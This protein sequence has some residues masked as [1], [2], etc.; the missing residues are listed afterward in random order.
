M[1]KKTIIQIILLAILTIFVSTLIVNG[2]GINS[3]Y[4]LGN[5]IK[6]IFEID[7][8]IGIL[9]IVLFSLKQINQSYL[10]Y[11]SNQINKSYVIIFLINFFS[12]LL[13]I[14][15]MIISLK[16]S[17]IIGVI[18]L[19]LEILIPFTYIV[20]N[21][22]SN[23]LNYSVKILKLKELFLFI[24]LE[25]LIFNNIPFEIFGL[26]IDTIIAIGY[27]IFLF[28]IAYNNFHVLFKKI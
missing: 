28:N 9:L 19:C 27:I 20:L 12:S 22:N 25:L 4:I 17:A 26:S 13:I 15:A 18:I 14:L 21:Q 8:L 5:N 16:I 23:E 10:L 7:L 1:K 24:L 3:Q 11:I 2:Y 6:M